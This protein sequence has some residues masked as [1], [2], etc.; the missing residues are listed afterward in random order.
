M[1]YTNNA[2]NGGPVEITGNIIGA[3]GGDKGGDASPINITG[4]K[5]GDVIT[6]K[7]IEI[8]KPIPEP[9]LSFLHHPLTI[10]VLGVIGAIIASFISWKY[11]FN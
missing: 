2:G 9:T 10:W 6:T 4:G 5:G 8:E 11:G 7:P 1:Q 3:P